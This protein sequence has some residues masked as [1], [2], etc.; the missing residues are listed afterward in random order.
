VIFKDRRYA[1]AKLPD[2][3]F[4]ANTFDM[5]KL[6][7][8]M[9]KTDEPLQCRTI[10]LSGDPSNHARISRTAR[11]K[12]A[13]GGALE[14][15]ELTWC[16]FQWRVNILVIRKWVSGYSSSKECGVISVLCKGTARGFAVSAT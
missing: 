5:K 9:Y 2:L 7:E 4:P 8:I 13:K 10:T 1:Q 15:Y 3:P 16:S 11:G 6:I 14:I 12:M